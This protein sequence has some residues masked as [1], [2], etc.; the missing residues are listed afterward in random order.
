MAPLR[1]FAPLREMGF[2]I[3]AAIL[4]KTQRR[5]GR[6]GE[7]TA[8]AQLNSKRPSGCPA[9]SV[10]NFAGISGLVILDLKAQE[11]VNRFYGFGVA[12]RNAY[13]SPAFHLFELV[14]DLR[15]QAL[16]RGRAGRRLRMDEHRRGEI[17]FG[18][19]LRDMVQVSANLVAADD[20]IGVVGFD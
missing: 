6:K 5:E 8:V 13:A 7:T 17:A 9:R 14:L 2:R 1:A 4:A 19:F 15:L 3:Q 16:H 20:V 12:C 18:K 11:F 10:F